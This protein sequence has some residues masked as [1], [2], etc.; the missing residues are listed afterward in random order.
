MIRLRSLALLLLSLA[1]CDGKTTTTTTPAAVTVVQLSPGD[2][3]CPHGGASFEAGGTTAYACSGANGSQGIQG[4]AGDQGLQGIQ[5]FPGAP[6]PYVTRTNV[7]CDTVVAGTS[8]AAT[9]IAECRDSNDLPIH[10]SCQQGDRDDV[11]NNENAPG[12]WHID[13]PSSS[14]A[15]YRCGWAKAQT[16]VTIDTMPNARA[17]ICCVDVP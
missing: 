16:G 4:L 7:Y 15:Q 13:S 10:G 14:K 12:G 1:A 9:L 11:V 2:P 17:T 8:T 3:T 6:S 5:G